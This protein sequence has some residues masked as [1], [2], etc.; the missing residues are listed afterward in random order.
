[1]SFEPETVVL[2]NPRFQ[3]EKAKKETTQVRKTNLN[4]NSTN[5][6]GKKITD[7]DEL[8]KQD[9]VGKELGLKIQQARLAKKL[10]QAD[11]AKSLNILSNDYQKYENGKAVRNGQ[12]LNKLGKIL[13]VK[14]TGKGV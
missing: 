12:M 5:G 9:F 1:M 8:P 4:K 10:K 14:L 13:G 11:V 3:K 6:S 7:E 2:R